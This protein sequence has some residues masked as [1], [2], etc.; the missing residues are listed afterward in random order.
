M[1]SH[2]FAIVRQPIAAKGGLSQLLRSLPE[3]VQHHRII[4]SVYSLLALLE[5]DELRNPYVSLSVSRG[6]QQ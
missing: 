5:F 4:M 1:F 6:N 2:V 3:Q